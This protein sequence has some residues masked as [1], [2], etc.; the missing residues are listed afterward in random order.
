LRGDGKAALEQKKRHDK[1]IEAYHAAYAKYTHDC[2]KLLDWI[3]PYKE[4]KEKVKEDFRNADCV[5]KLCGQTH[6]GHPITDP[7]ELNSLPFI[8]PASRNKTT[9]SLWPAV[10]S[11]SAMELLFFFELFMMLHN[12]L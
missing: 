10:R 7:K 9:F 3:I 6:L 12:G 2:T 8:N 4:M 5:D 1:A 11:L